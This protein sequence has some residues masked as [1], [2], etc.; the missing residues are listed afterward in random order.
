MK[1]TI[2]LLLCVLLVAPAN[3]A[4]TSRPAPIQTAEELIQKPYLDL[5]ELSEIQT[6]SAATSKLLKLNSR[7]NRRPN[8]IG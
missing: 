8:R 1:K 7:R 3:L 4:A 2:A 6:F 5:L